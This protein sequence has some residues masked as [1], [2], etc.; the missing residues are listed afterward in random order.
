MS[1]VPNARA[2]GGHY[3]GWLMDP[4]HKR[5]FMDT[6][7]YVGGTIKSVVFLYQCF[8]FLLYQLTMAS[9]KKRPWGFHEKHPYQQLA[10]SVSLRRRDTDASAPVFLPS[11]SPM[12]IGA[13]VDRPLARVHDAKPVSPTPDGHCNDG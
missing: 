12:L 5:A 7:S 6:R 11:P 8:P 13:C 4:T 10:A 9:P 2:D 1:L 3:H